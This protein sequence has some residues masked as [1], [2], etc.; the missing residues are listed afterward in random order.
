MKYFKNNRISGQSFLEGLIISLIVTVF[1]FAAIQACI[2]VVDDMYVNFAAFNAVRTVSVTENKNITKA[3]KKAV[4][5]ALFAYNLQSASIFSYETTN[6]NE[7][8]LGN[9]LKDHAGTDIKK[10]NVKVGYAVNVMFGKLFDPTGSR[11][12]SARARMVK[13]PDEQY[14]RKAYP[15][16]KEFPLFK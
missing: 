8:I 9:E 15:N 11:R 10:H 14:Y 12:Q 3:A 2:M 7:K 4:S 1:M 16:A 6:W 5:D 13:S